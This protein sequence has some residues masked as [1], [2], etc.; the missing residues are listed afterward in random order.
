M[1]FSRPLLVVGD[2]M[3]DRYWEGDVV[4][5]SPEAP[6]P[7]LQVRR[8]FSRAGGAANVALNLAALG[9]PVT[10]LT[11]VGADEAGD[12]LLGIL[13]RAGVTVHAVGGHR[14]RT[15]QKIRCVAQR[16]QLLRTD[17]E[18]PASAECVADLCSTFAEVLPDDGVVVLSDYAKGALRHCDTLIDQAHAR[19]CQVLCDPK[20]T[21]FGRYRGADVLK[22]N[23]AELRAVVGEWSDEAELQKKC[24]SLRRRLGLG[25]LLVTRGDAGMT[26]FDAARMRHHAADV[27]DV[28]DVSGAGDTVLATLAAF[29]AAGHA[30]DNCVRWANRA[31]GLAVAKFGTATVTLAEL[32]AAHGALPAPALASVGA[33]ASARARSSTRRPST[34]ARERAEVLQ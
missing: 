23:A 20:G 8:E 7:V 17:F 24:R 29:L 12:A 18:E 26:L 25:A 22:P 19:R 5:I 9:A 4:R 33:P 14:H 32:E 3:L 27:R 30:L 28:F 2:S 15:T 10:L 13:R 31:A 16:H 11:L 34:A 1:N 6:V 21:E